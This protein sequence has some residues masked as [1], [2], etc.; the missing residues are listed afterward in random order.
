MSRNKKKFLSRNQKLLSHNW[1]LAACRNGRRDPGRH[2]RPALK[3]P[4]ARHQSL[5]LEVF[6]TYGD[7]R[8]TVAQVLVASAE[9]PRNGS[10]ANRTP[11]NQIARAYAVSVLLPRPSIASRWNGAL[12]S[13]LRHAP[14]ERFLRSRCL[15]FVTQGH[16]QV[17]DNVTTATMAIVS[18]G[19]HLYTANMQRHLNARQLEDVA[20]MTCAVSDGLASLI[21]E[22]HSW[23]I[24][25]L[26]SAGQLLRAHIGLTA[27]AHLSAGIARSFPAKR[28]DST[29]SEVRKRSAWAVEKNDDLHFRAASRVI[30]QRLGDSKALPC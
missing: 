26:V 27:A 7:A 24:A 1:K 11:P 17:T 4:N 9:S 6:H 30:F 28:Q 12:A 10:A 29:L 5:L 8:P 3:H 25:A 14:L 20:Q 19:L 2:R 16:A 21:H 18:T 15:P 23:R 13:R 22:P